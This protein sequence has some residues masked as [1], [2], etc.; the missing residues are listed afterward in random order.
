MDRF[1]RGRRPNRT[2]DCVVCRQVF[3]ESDCVEATLIIPVEEQEDE[4]E[5]TAAAAGAG[6]EKK[7]SG[8]GGARQML[9]NRI[10]V[11]DARRR[12][13]AAGS[14]F[15]STKMKAIME[16]IHKE[17]AEDYRT[18]FLIFSQWTRMLD[19][20]EPVLRRSEVD[21]CR[22]DGSLNHQQREESVSAFVGDGD[23][24][25]MLCSLMCASLGLHLVPEGGRPCHVIICDPWWNPRCAA[26]LLAAVRCSGSSLLRWLGAAWRT[27]PL[28]ASI[29]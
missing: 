15:E 23:V 16:I 7:E 21:F 5:E 3:C 24:T 27:R 28:T 10:T 13:L 9:K 11:R 29:G 17:L 12:F 19:V 6:A 22:Y 25:V 26:R 8:D 20:L 18:K 4:V 14:I 2:A 1:G